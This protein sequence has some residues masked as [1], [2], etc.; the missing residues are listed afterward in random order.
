MTGQSSTFSAFMQGLFITP[1][2][3]WF[4]AAI[5]VIIIL[6]LLKLP[7]TEV[8]IS[9]TLLWLRSLQD[10]TANAPFQRLRKNLLLLLQILIALALGLALARPYMRAEMLPGQYICLL[11]DRSASMQTLEKEGTRLDLAKQSALR[12]VNEMRW[13]DRMMIV[14][15]GET[16]DVLVELTEDRVRLR[17]VIESIQP[18]D[19]ST[20]MRDAFFVAQS[21][22]Q[23]N[24]ALS[25]IV[26]TDGNVSDLAEILPRTAGGLAAAT[27]EELAREA[28]MPELIFVQVG[29]T[30][31]N[32]GIVRL[33]MR[34]PSEGEGEQ[35]T[36]ALVH[37]ESAT[38]LQT[39]LTLYFNSEMVGVS[40]VNA[41][42]G[43]DAEV[44]FGHAD[45]GEGLLRAVLDTE[46]ALAV[47]N[48]AWLSVRPAAKLRVLLVSEP[49]GTSTFF[50][51]RVFALDP[52]VDLETVA[53]ANYFTSQEYDLIVFNG[54]AP[55]ELPRGSLL[56]FNAVPPVEGI[57]VLGELENPP[58]IASDADHPVMRYLNP[59]NVGIA[60]ATRLGLPAGARTLASTN[61]GPLIAD[62]SR[63]GQQILVVP[64]N[65]EDS[66]WPLNL[67][68][69]LFVQN[70][71]SW[72]PRAALSETRTT[73]AGR[74]LSLPPEPL[75]TSATVVLP[76]GGEFEVRLDAMRP[77]Y[78][79]RTH[80]T[81]PYRV[82]IGEQEMTYAVNLLDPVETAIAPAEALEIGRGRVEAQ[83]G[84]VSVNREFWRWLV[85]AGI[86]ILV[87]EWWVYSRRAWV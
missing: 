70:V 78:F 64:F 29:E 72:T 36:F 5:P 15:F 87:L 59:S 18:T 12:L 62:V 22:R 10:L 44:L 67:S 77:T 26:L 75:A 54:F 33:S 45:L 83:K 3:L 37:N 39:T 82:R 55:P 30:R 79:A 69:P 9:S 25:A 80:E 50:L 21:L 84:N 1:A 86:A 46:D 60:K 66:D 35:Q 19:E 58:V 11:I 42:P 17:E 43:E 61:G 7:R 73:R 16:A 28:Q 63:G 32:A 68:F 23:T 74:P 71:L 6:Y 56:F 24:T 41:A 76:D 51:Q 81:G 52:R 53:P 48:E 49:K 34:K 8:V 57:E 2:F 40:E 31:D 27:D 47:D 38:G 14:T 85:A 13:G 65:L 20:K 4:L